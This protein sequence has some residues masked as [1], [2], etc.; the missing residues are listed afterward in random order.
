MK[1]KMFGGLPEKELNL[2][3]VD[4]VLSNEV[5]LVAVDAAGNEIDGGCLVTVGRRGIARNVYVNEYLGLPLDDKGRVK[6][7]GEGDLT[8]VLDL[9]KPFVEYIKSRDAL[10]PGVED[11]YAICGLGGTPR[12]YIGQFRALAKF[13]GANK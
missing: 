10:Y 3:V 4:R 6:I 9:I 2:R 7:D 1:I 8:E 13:Y 5:S 12:A 11:S